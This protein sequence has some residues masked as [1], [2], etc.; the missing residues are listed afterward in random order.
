MSFLDG[1]IS[2]KDL[3]EMGLDLD[4]S[5]RFMDHTVLTLETMPRFNQDLKARSLMRQFVMSRDP[6]KMKGAQ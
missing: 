3:Q 6:L 1:A 4:G 2:T 5:S